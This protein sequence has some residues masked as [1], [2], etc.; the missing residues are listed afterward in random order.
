RQLI[1]DTASDIDRL[2]RDAIERDEAV[3]MTGIYNVIAKLRVGQP[4]TDAERRVHDSAACGVLR[5]LHYRLDALVATAYGWSWPMQ[6]A[7]I[8]DALVALHG[9]RLRHEKAG[10]IGW[11]R[12]SYQHARFGSEH[13][14]PLPLPVEEHAAHATGEAVPT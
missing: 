4:L 14:P 9:E 6:R 8:L 3:T 12:P 5:D 13:A 10:R 11:L 2:R 1:S 7:E